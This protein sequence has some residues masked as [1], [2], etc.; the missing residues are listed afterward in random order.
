MLEATFS[1]ISHQKL[2]CIIAGDFN[3]DLLQWDTQKG[4]HDYLDTVTTQNFTPLIIL[5]TRITSKSSTLIDHIYFYAGKTNKNKK[6]LNVVI[7]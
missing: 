4:I 6:K 3:I 5:P 7:W 1:K 2:P